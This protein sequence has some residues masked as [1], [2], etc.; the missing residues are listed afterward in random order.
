MARTGLGEEQSTDSYNATVDLL[1]RNLAPGRAGRP[2]LNT[3]KRTWSYEEVAAGADAAG[4]G[5]LGMGIEPGDRVVV[6]LRDSPEFVISF[7]GTMKAG[8]IPVPVTIGLSTPDVA[9]ILADSEA[10]AVICDTTTADIVLGALETSKRTCIVV[11]GRTGSGVASWDDV[12]GRPATLDPARTT[13]EDMALWLYTSGTTGIPKAVMHRHRHLKVQPDGLA[14]QV[15][16]MG[17]D[18][19][20]LSVSKMFFAYGLGNSVYL[21]AATGASAVISAGPDARSRSARASAAGSTGTDG[22]PDSDLF[23]SS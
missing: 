22:C 6:A 17:P 11:G 18:D 10:R 13:G 8:I 4:A 2:Y 3:K 16:G 5:L 23:R 19:V 12:C 14:S 9:F 1:E 15:L 7:W 21:P 20:V